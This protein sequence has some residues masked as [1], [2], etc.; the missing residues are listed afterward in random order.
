MH[1]VND[2]RIVNHTNTFRRT[3]QS[4]SLNLHLIARH[5]RRSTIC[6]LDL[7]RSIISRM[8]RKMDGIACRLLARVERNFTLLP[9]Y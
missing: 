3:Y 6:V 4:S 8:D 1:E 2:R 9:E 5:R 7:L